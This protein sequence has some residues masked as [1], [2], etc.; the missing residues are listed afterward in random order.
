MR[1][2]FPTAAPVPVSRLF[3]G[4]RMRIKYA[5]AVYAAVSAFALILLPAVA[6]PPIDHTVE[7][8]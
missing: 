6:A 3:V 2:F 7:F 8:R 5:T 1:R 4:S